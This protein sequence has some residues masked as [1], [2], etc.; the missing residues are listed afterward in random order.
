MKNIL[1]NI[2]AVIAGALIGSF[3]NMGIIKVQGFF[4]PLPEG[5]NIDNFAQS[6]KLLEPRHFLMPFLAHSIG[7]LI[8]ALIAALIS[9]NKKF[10]MALIV[11]VLFLFGG[12]SAIIMFGGPIWFSFADLIL[13]YIPMAWLGFRLS[14]LILKSIKLES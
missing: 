5:F 13:A 1:L 14:I 4:I 11:G 3:V 6:I 7:T 12:I 10:L 2:L 9:Q 8:G